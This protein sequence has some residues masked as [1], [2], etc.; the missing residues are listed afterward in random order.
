[1]I[2][3]DECNGEGKVERHDPGH[4]NPHK[5]TCFHCDGRGWLLAETVQ[6]LCTRAEGAEAYL[7]ATQVDQ[8]NTYERLERLEAQVRE[9]RDKTR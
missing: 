2:K 8:S 9:L 4:V 5:V 7:K 1:M 6:R 3:C